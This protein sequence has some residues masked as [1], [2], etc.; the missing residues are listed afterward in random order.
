MKE[1]KAKEIRKAG[2]KS[3]L[4]APEQ[5][6]FTRTNY[7]LFALGVLVII[8]GYVALA[9]P[10]VNGFMSLTVAPILLIAGYCI[11]IPLAI[12]YQNKNGAL[13]DGERS[14]RR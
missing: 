4:K 13:A 12:L 8:V 5:L 1:V 9:Q 7:L 14:N 10:P 6:T 11:I 3:A 2:R